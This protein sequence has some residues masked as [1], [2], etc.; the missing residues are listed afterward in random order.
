MAA[1]L[2][3]KFELATAPLDEGTV[4]LE[5]S[6]GTGKTYTLTGIL[7]RMLLEGV[8]EH[9]EQA[10][11]VTFTVAA[12]DELKNRLRSAIQRAHS[13]CLGGK[14]DD[15]F[16]QSLQS[17]GKKGAAQLRRALDE[18]DQASVI[19]IHGFCKRLL[20]ESAFE[21]DEP[22]DLDFA[23]DE[24]P[25]WHQAAADS[26]RL[27]RQHDSLMLGAVMLE[28][29]LDPNSLV[30]LYRNWQR[31]PNVR[32]DPAQ[33]QL[34]VHL[35]NLRAAVHRAAAQWDQGLIEY[36]AGF[37]WRSRKAPSEGDLSQYLARATEPLSGRP[38][39]C[40]SL[41]GSLSLVQLEPNLTQK[42]FPALSQPFFATC[43]DVHNQWLLTVDH[44]R[45]ELLLRMHERLN[46]IKREQ[47]LLTFD[48]L[49]SPP[50]CGGV[51]VFW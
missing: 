1:P 27:L 20:D 37:P 4:L 8:V 34:G 23:I 15:K 33:P 49:L 38:E 5:A 17:F 35:A 22:F 42:G 3:E 25:L 32:L 41:L 30:H 26:L 47:A 18:F 39:L 7:V 13:V 11:V 6:A 50:T 14:D 29:K 24:A 36:I 16:F 45:A 21:S 46:R 10:L 12:A 44:L 9:I 19:T 2:Y 31:H 48:D 40:L 28:A 43:D 51:K